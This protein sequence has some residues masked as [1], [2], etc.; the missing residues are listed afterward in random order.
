MK[1]DNS[2]VSSADVSA[3]S[4]AKKADAA[5]KTEKKGPVSATELLGSPAASTEISGKAKEA[6]KAKAIATQTPDVREDKI[7]ALK[8]R[9][10]DGSYKVDSKAIADKLVD[11]HLASAAAGA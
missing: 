2:R 4:S 3:A 6:S 8:A 11:E 1:V 7:A 5:K 10:A 9:I